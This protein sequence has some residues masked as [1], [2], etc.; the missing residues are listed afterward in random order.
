MIMAWPR[1]SEVGFIVAI[2]R[3]VWMWRKGGGVKRRSEKV[4][5]IEGSSMEKRV[6]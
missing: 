6:G 1:R 3:V 2:S 5:V 4:A